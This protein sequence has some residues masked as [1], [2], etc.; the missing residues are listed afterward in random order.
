MQPD[1]T[2]K[3]RHF[4]ITATTE[5]NAQPDLSW[6]EDGSIAEALDS[7]ELYCF[8]TIVRVYYRG[9][10]VAWQ[11]LGESIYADSRDFFTGHRDRDPMNRNCTIMRAAR[12]DILIGHYFPD[13]VREAIREARAHFADLP[14]LRAVA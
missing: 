7:G 3:T 8:D 12:G 14:R 5:F 2:F 10:E 13:M 9:T 11:Y 1:W 4:K 6:D